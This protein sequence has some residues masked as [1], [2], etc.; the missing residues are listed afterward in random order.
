[1]HQNIAVILL[2]FN[3]GKSSIIV[4]IPGALFW[5]NKFFSLKLQNIQNR[6]ILGIGMVQQRFVDLSAAAVS[7]TSLAQKGKN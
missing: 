6:L 1:M 7:C 3:Y 4:L 5:R 2:Q